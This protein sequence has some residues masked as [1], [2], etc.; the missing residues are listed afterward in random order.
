MTKKLNLQVLGEV[1]YA[2]ALALQKELH[3]KVQSGEISDQLLILIHGPVITVGTSTEPEHLLRNERE[4]YSSG[5]GGSVTYHGPEQ[6]IC[7]PILDLKRHKQ[8]VAWYMRTL[9]EVVIRS[10]STF[11]V[12]AR[13]IPEKTGVWTDENSKIAFI[14][15]KISRWCTYHGF[16]INL[17]PCADK[18]K[19]IN[20]CGLGEIVVTSIAEQ[21][22][23][24]HCPTRELLTREVDKQ[25]R[26]IFEY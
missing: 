24:T 16:S 15:I 9:E 19:D 3:L 2:E 8:D 7:Y 1:P 6:I 4:V 14:G 21:V 26:E 5:R 18:F 17:L 12:T 22:T 20:P 10:L 11:G 23:S 13:Q 25:F